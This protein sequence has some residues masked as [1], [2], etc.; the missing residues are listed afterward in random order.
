MPDKYKPTQQKSTEKWGT[1]APENATRNQM[2][3]WKRRFGQMP[4]LTTSMETLQT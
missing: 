2:Q 4:D 1:P 3:K